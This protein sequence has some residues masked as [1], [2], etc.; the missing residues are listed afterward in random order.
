MSV[1]VTCKCVQSV[2]LKP[3]YITQKTRQ[4]HERLS[5]DHNSSSSV[6]G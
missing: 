1:L 4:C 2:M 5:T 6:E 3:F